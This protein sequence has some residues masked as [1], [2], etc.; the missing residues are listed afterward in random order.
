MINVCKELSYVTLEHPRRACV[1]PRNFP[2]KLP[3]AIHSFVYSFVFTA[4]VGV[5]DE[6][7][8]KERVELPIDRMMHQ[9]ILHGGLMDV[10]RFGIVDAKCMIW[11]VLVCSLSQFLVETD[12]AIC[13]MH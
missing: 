3:K 8:V 4:G 5:V 9:A 10:T 6:Q 11:S 7:S 13:Q 2:C 12:N 1:I